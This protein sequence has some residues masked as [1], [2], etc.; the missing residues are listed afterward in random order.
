MT[1]ALALISAPGAVLSVADNALEHMFYACAVKL[2][3][4]RLLLSTVRVPYG[5]R[6]MHPDD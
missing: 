4:L 3:N 5:D 2:I 6:P 1:T